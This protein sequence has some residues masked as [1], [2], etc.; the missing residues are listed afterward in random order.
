MVFSW[1]RARRR[2]RLAALPFPAP[3]T[4]YLEQNVAHYAL[5]TDVERQRLSSDLRVLVVEKNWEGCGG[6]A[7]TDEIKVTIAA[8]ASLLLLGIEHDFYSHVLSVLVYPSTFMIPQRPDPDTWLIE[9]EEERLGEAWYRGPVILAWD[10]VQ[11]DGRDLS[12]GRNL[13]IHEFAHQLDFA[14]G[15]M[16]GTPPLRGGTHRRQWRNV[17]T[18]EYE[19]LI[20]DADRGRATV[21]DE[22]GATDPCEF[23]AVVS[24]C[25]FTRPL[26]MRDR[27]PQLYVL[28]QDY[29]GQDTA[30]RE[31]SRGASPR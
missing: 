7:I 28:L 31:A 8:Q 23:F 4:N 21:L 24:E 6:L 10:T 9:D 29:Y 3:W 20:R 16:N 17:M 1:I 5:L 15:M 30:A 22:Y 11:A 27:H 19:A 14:D 26:A 2:R 25:F 12:R 18:R 13:V